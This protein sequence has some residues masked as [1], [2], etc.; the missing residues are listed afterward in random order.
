MVRIL[1]GKVLCKL[2]TFPKVELDKLQVLIMFL[3]KMDCD[4][5]TSDEAVGREEGRRKGE[6]DTEVTLSLSRR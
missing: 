6:G 4:V 3:C 2:S 5:K 1:E